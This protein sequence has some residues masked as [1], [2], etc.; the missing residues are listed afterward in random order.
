MYELNERSLCRKQDVH[1]TQ[2]GI[3]SPERCV[4]LEQHLGWL[5]PHLLNWHLLALELRLREDFMA[6]DGVVEGMP[7]NA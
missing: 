2:Q 5:E 3:Y 6:V 4:P 7:V 1:F